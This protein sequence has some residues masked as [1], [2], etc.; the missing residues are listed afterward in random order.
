M[1]SFFDAL[2]NVLTGFVAPGISSDII[3]LETYAGLAK[4]GFIAINILIGYAVS[5]HTGFRKEIIILFAVLGV[6]ASLIVPAGMVLVLFLLY[7]TIFKLFTGVMI[8][9][10][11]FNSRIALIGMVAGF[12][13]AFLFFLVSDGIDDQVNL[14]IVLFLTG[15]SICSVYFFANRLNN[16]SVFTNNYI[17]IGLATMVAVG[18]LFP[19][20]ELITVSEPASGL[21]R[22]SRAMALEYTL[23]AGLAFGFFVQLMAK[24]NNA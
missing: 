7:A 2:I 9:M 11:V 12:V 23:F 8:G 15:Y 14:M 5:E 19:T 1:N 16:E 18:L 10:L 17:L 6:G 22:F 21:S 3:S 20:K 13:L 24:K 4:M